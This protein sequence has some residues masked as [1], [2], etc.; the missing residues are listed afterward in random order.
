MFL[1]KILNVFSLSASL[2]ARGSVNTKRVIYF[3]GFIEP[4]L[5][6]KLKKIAPVNQ[7][8]LPI[9]FNSLN[10]KATGTYST[11][12]MGLP[13]PTS[14]FSLAAIVVNKPT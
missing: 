9:T 1:K 12:R 13:F 11:L 6:I 8:F 7:S 4:S 5:L 10:E 2:L 14:V 3:N